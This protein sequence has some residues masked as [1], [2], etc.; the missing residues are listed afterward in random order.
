LA[1]AVKRE[2]GGGFLIFGKTL[3][4]KGREGLAKDAKKSKI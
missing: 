1:A 4:R 3:N 2:K